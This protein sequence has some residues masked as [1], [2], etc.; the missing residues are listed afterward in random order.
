MSLGVPESNMELEGLFKGPTQS[1]EEQ[2]PGRQEPGTARAKTIPLLRSI[3]PKPALSGEAQAS[4][5]RST[6]IPLPKSA[7]WKQK[8]E[9]SGAPGWLRR[10]GV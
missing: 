8:G 5:R 2:T 4:A 7:T 6:P 1:S 9:A 3:L 10:L